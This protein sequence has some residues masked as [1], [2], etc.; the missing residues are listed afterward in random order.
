MWP[1]YSMI[2][3]IVDN[4][5]YRCWLLDLG[6]KIMHD[7]RQYSMW[8]LKLISLSSHFYVLSFNTVIRRIFYLPCQRHLHS[9]TIRS[10]AKIIH[11]IYFYLW[12]LDTPKIAKYRCHAHIQY[13]YAHDPPQYA[14]KKYPLFFQKKNYSL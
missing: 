8:V 12:S 9:T 6:N 4:L 14:S 7:T 3:R 2:S 11:I 1:A 5:I 10:Q 13:Q